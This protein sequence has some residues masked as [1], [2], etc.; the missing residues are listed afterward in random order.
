MLKISAE[1]RLPVIC[2]QLTSTLGYQVVATTLGY[3]LTIPT[4]WCR[5]YNWSGG[6]EGQISKGRSTKV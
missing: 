3:H 2:Q 5:W 6:T 1:S 4:H